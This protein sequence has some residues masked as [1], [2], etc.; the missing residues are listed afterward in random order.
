M[1]QVSSAGDR[2]SRARA[3]RRARLEALVELFVNGLRT[4]WGEV[5][6]AIRSLRTEDILAAQPVDA[7]RR[8]SRA[9]DAGES[10]RPT[11]HRRHGCC[12]WR[13]GPGPLSGPDAPWPL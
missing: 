6:A 13:A 1:T 7:R 10:R 3:G 11:R 9:A 8:R 2:R 4:G 12:L 5:C